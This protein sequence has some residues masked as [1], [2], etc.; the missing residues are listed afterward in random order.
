MHEA[1]DLYGMDVSYFTG[2]LEAYL[3]YKAIPYRRIEARTRVMQKVLAPNAGIAK[4]PV[5]HAPT[6]EWLQDTTP[7][8]DWLEARHPEGSVIPHDPEQAFFCRLV[9][10]Y[11]D[12][13]MWRPALHYRW[14]YRADARALGG[15]IAREVADV[16]LPAWA[17][18]RIVALRQ[19]REYVRGDGVRAE[20][21][22]H[23]EGIY[24]DTLRR[25]E[26]LLSHQPF[27]LG[28][29][30]SLADFGFFGSMFRHFSLDPTPGRI[31]RDTA[32]RVFGWVARLWASRWD[33]VKG[34]W[35]VA[36]AIP[37]AWGPIL[38]DVGTGY[39]PYLHANAVAWT[40]GKKR[41]DWSVQGV[42]YRQ[43]PVVR[44]RVWC[45]ER[46]QQ[47]F[48]ALPEE[49]KARVRARLEAHAA[50]APLWQDGT[51][52]SRLHDGG[53]PPVCRRPDPKQR[54]RLARRG[55]TS[56]NLPG[57]FR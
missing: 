41:F 40:Q 16:P 37:D 14:S 50:W 28:D 12:E 8:I 52:A 24:L 3:R 32:P 2:K 18:A 22:A 21:R 19:R 57:T 20:T 1:Y 6:G 45:R 39:L 53:T 7:I 26:E 11:A 47:H 25:L 5:L 17:K 13:W 55:S 31:M 56:W 54:A 10:D 15:R 49:A 33:E 9:E 44:Y 46:L 4:V 27:L 36:G 48:D 51:I 35:P 30:P 23:V 38:D 42:R 34:D 43:T 29:R